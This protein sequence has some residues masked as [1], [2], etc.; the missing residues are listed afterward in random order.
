M[1]PLTDLEFDGMNSRK[2][3]NEIMETL[4]LAEIHKNPGKCKAAL[5]RAVN[6]HSDEP[7]FCKFK[8]CYG[9]S[10]KRSRGALSVSDCKYRKPS[11]WRKMKNLVSAGLITENREK[12][13]DQYMSR[14]W[15]WMKVLRPIQ[16]PGGFS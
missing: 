9:N 16:T 10:W 7:L 6:G 13:E 4:L 12:V 11:V 2:I 15:D 1:E 3:K 14:G 8:D 5:C